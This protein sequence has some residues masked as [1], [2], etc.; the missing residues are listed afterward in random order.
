MKDKKRTKKITLTRSRKR[1]IL[2]F[3]PQRLQNEPMAHFLEKETGLRCTGGENSALPSGKHLKGT[4]RERLILVDC[5]GQ[6]AEGC[7]TLLDSCLAMI[8]SGTRVALFNVKAGLGIEE[9]AL[10]RGVTGFFYE[11]APLDLLPKGVRAI[12]NGELWVSREIMAKCIVAG[13]GREQDLSKSAT[14]ILTPRE[15]EILSM[16]AMGAKNEDIAGELYISPNTV[17]T[18][19]YN[20]FRK[21]N[22]PNRLQAALW[23]AKNL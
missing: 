2:V 16:V 5:L 1:E 4:G 12:L 9:K 21:I 22:V 8:L 7:L 18:H 10:G 20:I 15:I 13:T 6:D 11:E 19:V 3:G 14:I 17:K 23:A